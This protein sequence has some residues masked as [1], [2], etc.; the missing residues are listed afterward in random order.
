MS[1][2]YEAVEVCPHCG[3][4]NVY[5]GWDTEEQGYIAVCQQCKQAIFLC[6]ECLHA[7]DN[8]EMHCNWHKFFGGSSCFRG[9]IAKK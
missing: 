2:E 1:E 8:E 7:G 3:A 5:P 9:I 6:D 4:E